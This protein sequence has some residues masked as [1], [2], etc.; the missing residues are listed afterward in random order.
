[1]L[2]G[3][4]I[5]GEAGENKLGSSFTEAGLGGSQFIP[6]GSQFIPVIL[7]VIQLQCVVGQILAPIF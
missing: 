6:A 2:N 1:M 7:K 5:M 3:G 4:G